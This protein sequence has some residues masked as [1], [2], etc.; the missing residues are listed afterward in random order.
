MG[1]IMSEV[2]TNPVPPLEAPPVSSSL[3]ALASLQLVSA[4]W[5][6]VRPY[7]EL[8]ANLVALLAQVCAEARR[9]F[10]T[11][12][13]CLE[14]YRDPEIAD[15]Y[16]TVYVRV[17]EYGR[18]TID[19]IERIAMAVSASECPLVTTDFRLPGGENVLRLEDI[20]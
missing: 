20:R 5:G 14:L 6:R 9:E 19:R 12:E 18:D 3:D 11:P 7:V 4:N 1:C 10:G 8:H 17:T 2:R 16:L 13:L 15:E